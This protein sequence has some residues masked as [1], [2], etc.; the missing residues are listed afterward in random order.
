MQCMG[1]ACVTRA[2]A[3]C[4]P[5]S[6]KQARASGCMPPKKQALW[7]DGLVGLGEGVSPKERGELLAVARERELRVRT[8]TLEVLLADIG[9]RQALEE[10]G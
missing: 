3:C 5:A 7:L 2:W 6:V 9:Q 8:D 1:Q 10:A 4:V